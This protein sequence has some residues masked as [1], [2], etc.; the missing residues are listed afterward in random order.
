[1]YEYVQAVSGS[2]PSPNSRCHLDCDSDEPALQTL[3]TAAPGCIASAVHSVS[4]VELKITMS[5]S[6]VVILDNG[7]GFSKI[8]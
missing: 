7:T 3:A 6:N 8:G 4:K 2:Q 5:R 1:M